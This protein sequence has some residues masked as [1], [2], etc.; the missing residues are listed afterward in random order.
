MHAAA[1]TLDFSR[2]VA[3]MLLGITGHI[4]DVDDARSI[5]RRLLAACRPAVYL[6]LS[7]GTVSPQRDDAEELYNDSGG[8][9]YHA[10]T[11][12]QIVSFFDGL[13]LVEPGVVSAPLWRPEPGGTPTALDEFCGVGRKP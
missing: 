12:E 9:P 2:P 13:E 5:V 8:V 1:Q 6:V 11:L 7:D 3:L 10:R 4:E